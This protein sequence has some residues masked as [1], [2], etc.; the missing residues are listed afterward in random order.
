MLEE[1]VLF[2]NIF[3]QSPT[4]I[5][6]LSR[7][8]KYIAQNRAH[9]DL[10]G[11]SD[12]EVIGKS[13][14]FTLEQATIDLIKSS[15]E[16][17]I[18]F[19]GLVKEATS[20]GDI[21]EIEMDIYPVHSETNDYFYFIAMKREIQE[22]NN[23]QKFFLSDNPI[24]LILEN[25]F[26]GIIIIQKNEIIYSN[27]TFSV[28][29][30]YSKEYLKRIS[31]QE[32]AEKLFINNETINSDK[33]S[34][35][36]SEENFLHLQR[37]ICSIDDEERWVSLYSQEI[38]LYN[39]PTKIIYC[40]NIT[41]QKQIELA[42]KNSEEKFR[43]LA[44]KTPMAIYMERGGKFIYTNK[45]MSDNLG[46]SKEELKNINFLDIVHPEF[47]QKVSHNARSRL[48]GGNPED[49]Y[50]IKVVAKGGSELWID[51]TPT[52]FIFEGEK[53]ILG[54]AIDIT[55]RKNVEDE[56]KASEKKYRTLIEST[57]EIVYTCSRD[58][59]ITYISPQ[60]RSLG[61]EPED[62][63]GKSISRLIYKDDEKKVMH[64]LEIIMTKG[65][66]FPKEFRLR[67]K[68]GKNYY[69]F[70]DSGRIIRDY[71]GNIVGLTGFLRDITERKEALQLLKMSERR[72]HDLANNSEEWIWEIDASLKFIYSSH[73]VDKILGYTV[74]EIVSMKFEDIFD[75]ETKREYNSEIKKYFIYQEAFKK[76]KIK[77]K[78]KKGEDVWLSLNAIPIKN[79]N[80]V[81]IGYRGAGDDITENILAHEVL[82]RSE[83]YYRTIVDRALDGIFITSPSGN[84]IDV[85]TNGCRMLGYL[86]E[87]LLKFKIGDV[88]DN[89]EI[90]VNAI[91][92]QS[93]SS[94]N[95]PMFECNMKHKDGR[96]FPVEI[97][98]NI[99]PGNIVLSIIRDISRRKIIENRL[100]DSLKEKRVLL[101]EIHH[102]V[103]NNLQIISS[104]L[105]LQARRLD[106]DKALEKFD[107][108]QTRI[109]AMAL[110]HTKLYQ[111]DELD[112]LDLGE[113]LKSL[114][115]YLSRLFSPQAE[116]VEVSIVTNPVV[117]NLDKA[118]PCSLLVNELFSNALKHAFPNQEKGKISILLEGDNT[119]FT[120]TI[121]D[122]GVGLPDSIL[123]DKPNTLG[124]ILVQ[125]LTEQLNGD[126]KINRESGT[127]FIFDVDLT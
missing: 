122:N 44:D 117:I 110:V 32:L 9:E 70:E 89:D 15:I 68:P 100:K 8:M 91:N 43:I 103:K 60:I 49:R 41:E 22:S 88:I 112:R 10:L 121:K 30:G 87:E 97:N 47:R 66:E 123:L 90:L 104:I 18:K 96:T 20:S 12:E 2:R 45:V 50:Q 57:N 119:H 94:E 105:H 27:P 34:H 75:F 98:A 127:E 78:N 54:T 29:T 108:C 81:F 73:I 95:L 35:R 40:I 118:I 99:L 124:L 65:K 76:V 69:W 116:G 17:D 6:I 38:N 42:L 53:V 64:D 36:N 21:L 59:I 93:A 39:K 107:E 120:L 48:S 109:Q 61:Y 7:D 56:L 1:I 37:K 52:V 31:W 11:Y 82:R 28:F 79:K 101:K 74:S 4:A 72:F 5:S 55:D 126:L 114:M 13:L 125:S 86:W 19:S 85:N 26:I 92:F 113:F 77:V 71:N 24:K 33:K 46:Y 23:I 25:S 63:I 3:A 111:S 106:D 84:I 102:R 80:G 14:F 62:I 16:K 115:S 67:D 83:K 58:G 51:L